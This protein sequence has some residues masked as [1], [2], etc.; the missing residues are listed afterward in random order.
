MFWATAMGFGENLKREE[1]LTHRSDLLTY[2]GDLFCS[3]PFVNLA[4]F[5]TKILC[6]A[7]FEGHGGKKTNLRTIVA[8]APL[9]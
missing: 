9:V 1:L 2:G 5:R 6:F 3:L 8:R 4:R 7:A